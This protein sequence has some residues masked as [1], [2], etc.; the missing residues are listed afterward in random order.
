M[1]FLALDLCI[2]PSYLVLVHFLPRYMT[3][4]NMTAI[5]A[6]TLLFLP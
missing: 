5:I 4:I 3:L 6:D 1:S 2:L